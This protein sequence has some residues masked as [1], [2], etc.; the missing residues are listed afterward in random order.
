[1]IYLGLEFSSE[2]QFRESSVEFSSEF[3]VQRV[4]FSSVPRELEFSAR[5]RRVRV[6]ELW[7]PELWLVSG[8][9]LED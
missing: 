9:L 2:F 6:R 3:R 8:E 7:Y 5:V 1:V 4:H